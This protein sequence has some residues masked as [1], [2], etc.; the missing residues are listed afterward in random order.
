MQKY[1]VF[2]ILL[3]LMFFALPSYVQA[4]CDDDCCIM[5]YDNKTI[6]K[7]NGRASFNCPGGGIC[8]YQV[9]KYSV[10][11][12]DEDDC[13]DSPYCEMLIAM[14]FLLPPEGTWIIWPFPWPD[15]DWCNT[16]L[17]VAANCYDSVSK[18]ANYYEL[19]HCTETC[20]PELEDEYYSATVTQS[21][22]G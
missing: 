13:T 18:T 8:Y 19:D 15:Y 12:V 9:T 11:D 5:D 22:C 2:S 4:D 21:C 20:D 14:H 10:A 16:E 17:V 1:V 6:V 3:M 7:R